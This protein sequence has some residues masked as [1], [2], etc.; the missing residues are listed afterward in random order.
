MDHLIELKLDHCK[1]TVPC[2]QSINELNASQ[3]PTHCPNPSSLSPNMSIPDSSLAQY[4][5]NMMHVALKQAQK[6]PPRPT[7]FRVGA[8]LLAGA[9]PAFTGYTLE[10]EGNTHAEQVCF[11]KAAEHFG[12]SSSSSPALEE[13]LGLH[14]PDV[15]VLYTTMEP[16]NKRSEG[17]LPC[18]D[19]ILRLKRRDGRQAIKVVYVGVS[20][21]ETFV[22][23]NEGR[24]RLEEAGI[25]VVHV[26]GLESD[27]LKVATAGHEKGESGG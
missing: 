13:E 8:I 18:V 5:R 26:S 19:R 14:L 6:S 2:D 16:C 12:C 23:V 25:E 22:G 11:L 20:E 7:N 15:T 9:E 1:Q 27:I 21:P 4:Q 24:K 17:N 3:R 10:R